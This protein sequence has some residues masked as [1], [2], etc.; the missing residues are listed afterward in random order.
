MNYFIFTLSH[1]E[2]I[3]PITLQPL[4]DDS[5][6]LWWFG[7]NFCFIIKEV[8]LSSIFEYISGLI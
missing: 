5:D 1:N 4:I 8:T 7:H 2:Q 3:Q 6:I